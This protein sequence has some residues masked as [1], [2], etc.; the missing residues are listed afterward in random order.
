[1]SLETE[2]G[3]ICH[4][5]LVPPGDSP[6]RGARMRDGSRLCHSPTTAAPSAQQYP[7]KEAKRVQIRSSNYFYH[8]IVKLSFSSLR[9]GSKGLPGCPVK[10]QDKNLDILNIFP[11]KDGIT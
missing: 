8:Y 4:M 2:N 9:I 7:K 1:M 6:A 3:N 11:G 10:G 5:V